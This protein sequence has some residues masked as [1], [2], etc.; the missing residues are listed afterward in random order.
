MNVAGNSWSF[1]CRSSF[2][3]T[4]WIFNYFRWVRVG[5]SSCVDGSESQNVVYWL[6]SLTLLVSSTVVNAV[7]G[8]VSQWSLH[9]VLNLV[10]QWSLH[11]V[12]NLVSQWSLM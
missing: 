8:L 2:E 6:S 10:S 5:I 9:Y 4:L 1:R 3:D 12:L 7:S 11:Y